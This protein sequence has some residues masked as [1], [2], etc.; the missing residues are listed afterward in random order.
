M[1][2]A[3]FVKKSS[4]GYSFELRGLPDRI[5]LYGN[6]Y[7]GRQHLIDA[8]GSIRLL[9]D[10]PLDAGS[11]LKYPK[12]TIEHTNLGFFVLVLRGKNGRSIAHG[13]ECRSPASASASLDEI[14]RVARGAPVID[15]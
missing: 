11:S 7:A 13:P 12:Y 10:S 5:L 9:S 14:R 8:I 2:A 1:T 4:D 3:Y 15:Q 6:K